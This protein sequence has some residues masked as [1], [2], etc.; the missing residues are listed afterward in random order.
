MRS[1]L[2]RRLSSLALGLPLA[3]GAADAGLDQGGSNSDGFFGD[4]GTTATLKAAQSF[5]AFPGAG[6]SGAA[7]PLTASLAP[8]TSGDCNPQPSASLPTS[9]SGVQTVCFFSDDADVPA[10][11][12]EQVVEV[13]GTAEWVHIRLTLN[14]DFV[15]N[16]YGETAI[17]WSADA[18]GGVAGPAGPG[19]PKPPRV[20]GPPPLNGDAPPP[21]AAD[22][23][24]PTNADAPPPPAADSPPPRGDAPPP[25]AADGPPP[26]GDAPRPPAADGPAPA[27]GDAPPAPAAGGPARG[28]GDAPPGGGRPRPG[29][30]GHTFRDLVGSDHAEIE[31]LDANGQISVHFKLDYVSQSAAVAA[32]YASL[33]V[34]GGEGKLIVGEPEWIL[35]SASSID[36]NLNAC[37]LGSFLDDSPATDAAYTPNADASDWDYRVAYEVWV[38]TDA[39]GNAAFGSALI[40]NVHASP[41]KA[42]GDTANVLPA[43]CPVDPTDPEAVP[44]PLPVVLQT[45]R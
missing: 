35:A 31:L 40:S 32:G 36:R 7:Q 45:I 11:T 8:E 10:A 14:P 19:Q 5:V 26:R 6:T 25:P 12:I 13:V 16:T 44:Q 41:S 43:P 17:G 1:I 15:D 28:P 27:R 30:A 38:S 22:G 23:P 33:G 21:P 4:D 18:A 20:D 9:N 37:G 29:K 34:S 42:S 3:C 2:S 39:F 24:R